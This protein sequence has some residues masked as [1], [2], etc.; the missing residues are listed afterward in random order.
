MLLHTTDLTH[1]YGSH[2][3]FQG[4]NLQIPPKARIGLIGPNGSGKTTLLRVL[5]G[6]EEPLSGRVHR[7]KGLRIGY[8]PQTLDQ[9]PATLTLAALLDQPFQRLHALEARLRALEEALGQAPPQRTEALLARYGRAQDEYERLGGYTYQARQAR[10]LA[11]LGFAEHDL[12]RPLAQLSGGQRTRAH[13]ARLLLEEPDL[14]VLDE[15]TN[16]LDLAGVEFLERYLQGFP[17]AVLVVSHDRYFL[18][19]VTRTIWELSPHGVETYRGNYSAYVQQRA[20]RWAERRR[21]WQATMEQLQRDLAYIKRH[22][23]GQNSAQAKGRLKRLSRAV[24]ALEADGLRAL[25]VLHSTTWGRAVERL[26]LQT[27]ELTVAEAEQRLK[28]LRFPQTEPPTPQ[29]RLAPAQRSG[30][31][32]LRAR[33]LV[34]GYPDRPLF[35]APRLD[36]RRGECAALLGPNGS[37][38]TTFLRTILGHLEPLAGQVRLGPSVRLGYFAQA[39]A[40]LA[41]QRTVLDEVLTAAPHLLP[42]EARHHLARYLFRGDAVNRPVA[43]LSGGERAR[44]ALAKLELQ[45]ANFLLLDEPTNHLDIPAQEALQA[46]LAA[47]PGTILLVSH[48]RYLVRALATQIWSLARGHLQVFMGRYDAY[49][50]HRS[51]LDE[52][53]TREKRSA[54]GRAGSRPHARSSPP[55][56]GLSKNQRRKIER[57][58]AA[59]EDAITALEHQLAHL[60]AQLRQ[61]PRDPA[62]LRR[63]STTYADTQA[64]LDAHL[65]EWEALHLQLEQG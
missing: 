9:P 10:V 30:E 38:K 14:L 19:Q 58:I 17:G 47:Y 41:P 49:L 37:G 53:K 7:A 28:V 6:L 52:M 45:G 55:R 46:V 26:G 31:W 2:I 8:L 20:A 27:R 22:M 23:A 18:D 32:V 1:G 63:L 13:L 42:A 36:L 21:Q 48:D 24:L 16:H 29:P 15:P 33:D 64:A 5:L 51:T 65:A 34:V 59:L 56:P 4:L 3:L 60:E 12:P 50:Q 39:A 11:G 61:P 25:E 54:N 35:R 40:D 44:L 57:R 43:V 62:A